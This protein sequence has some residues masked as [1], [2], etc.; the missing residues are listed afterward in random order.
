MRRSIRDAPSQEYC[1]YARRYQ[2]VT[3]PVRLLADVSND[4]TSG[5]PAELVIADPEDLGTVHRDAS[6]LT[7]TDDL[8]AVWGVGA[9]L[10][11]LEVG[12]ATTVL[13]SWLACADVARNLGA[14]DYGRCSEW[15]CGRRRAEHGVV[16]GSSFGR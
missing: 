8:A 2:V 5:D 10:A 14:P 1:R 12:L 7:G 13:A 11:V 16:A 4:T 9:T 3:S 15:C 6:A